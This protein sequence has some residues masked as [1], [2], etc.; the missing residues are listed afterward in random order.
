[1]QNREAAQYVTETML[2]VFNTLTT[3][4]Q[5]INALVQEGKVS[6]AE[7]DLYRQSVMGPLDKMLVSTL[8]SVFERYPELRPASSCAIAHEGKGQHGS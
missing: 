6:S 4:V 8:T 1:M 7:A 2:A 5:Q 3:S